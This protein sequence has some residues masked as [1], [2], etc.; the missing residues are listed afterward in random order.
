M[1]ASECP[2]PKREGEKERRRERERERT[3]ESGQGLLPDISL[4]I[5]DTVAETVLVGLGT[6]TG[7][8]ETRRG[9]GIVGSAEI[10]VR[11]EHAISPPGVAVF[12]TPL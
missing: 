11:F 6:L 8:V 12:V 4:D 3:A 2:P 5:R 9:G 7:G 1:S 10:D